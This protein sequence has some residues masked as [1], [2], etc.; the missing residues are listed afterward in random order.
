MLLIGSATPLPLFAADSTKIEVFGLYDCYKIALKRSETVAI[1]KEKIEET[2]AQLLQAMSL[3]IG[4][5]DFVMS[6]SLEQVQK[7]TRTSIETAVSPTT[8]RERKFALTQPLFQGFKSLAAIRGVGSLH[9]ER[10][11][12]YVHAQQLLFLDVVNAYYSILQN[13]KDIDITNHIHKLLAERILELKDRER[14]GRSRTSEVATANAKIKSNE[15]D[16]ARLDG[17]L[18]VSLSVMEYLLGISITENQLKEEEVPGTE[19]P[20]LEEYLKAVILRPDVQAAKQAAKTAWQNIVVAQSSLWPLITFENNH[21]EKRE[22][23]D[24]GI[25]WDA[26]F[27]ISVPIFHGGETAGN[28]K[29][30]LSEW[31]ISKHS[32]TDTERQARLDIKQSYQYWVSSLNEFRAR[33]EAVKASAENFRLQKEEYSRSLVNNLDVLDAVQFLNQTELDANQVQH[34]MKKNYWKL[35]VA[36]RKAP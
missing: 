23:V 18:Q 20:P 9:K 31:K 17:V 15:A 24:S 11:E 21:Y 29:E 6:Q 4:R 10:G 33:E 13:K 3:A 26:L 35:Q 8:N 14:I 27:K 30:A 16:L 7:G 5:V 34:D 36:V 19:A 22:G 1:Q 12:E 32:E 28:I 25:N 2:E